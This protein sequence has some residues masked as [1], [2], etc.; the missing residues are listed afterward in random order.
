MQ[1]QRFHDEYFSREYRYSIGNDTNLG[2]KYLSIPVSNG[3]VDYEEYYALTPMQY[4]NFMSDQSGASAFAE[5]CRRREHDD[6]L[7]QK[8]GWNRGTP[9]LSAAWNRPWNSVC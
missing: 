6:L 4:D 1:Q 2:G 3:I 9:V 7:L 5:S 8:P